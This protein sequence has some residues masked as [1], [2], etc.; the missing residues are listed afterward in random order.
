M[1]SEVYHLSWPAAELGHAL[2]ALAQRS[3]LSP[4]SAELAAP[5][6]RIT[7]DPDAFGRWIE[8]A[9]DSLG[10]EAEPRDVSYPELAQLIRSPGPVL[11]RLPRSV[12][13]AEGLEFRFLAAVAGRRTVSVLGPDLQ[14]HQIDSEVVRAA[15][16]AELEAPVRAQVDQLLDAAQVPTRRRSQARAAILREMLSAQRFSG[17]W[18]IRL[19][20]STPFWQQLRQAGLARHV[21][22]LLAA[23]SFQYFLWLVSWW[24][25]GQGALQGRLDWGWLL[26]WGLLLLTLIPFRLLVTWRQGVLAVGAGGLLKNRLLHGALQL[27]PDDT[28]H[29]GMG[30]LLGRVMEADA[31]ESLALSGG[32]LALIAGIE[33][34]MAAGVLALGAGG[35][36]HALLLVVWLGLITGVG[37]SY[38]RQRQDW[39][40]AR[41]DMTHDLVERMVGHRTR[42]AQQAPQRWHAGEDQALA[43]Y[44]ERSEAMDRS[45][46][47]L[48][49]LAPRGWL[50]VG[51]CGLTPAFVSGAQSAASLAVGIGGLLLAF[52]ALEK[53][54]MSLSHLSGALIAWT[55]IAPLFHAARSS[56]ATASHTPTFLMLPRSDNQSDNRPIGQPVLEAHELNFRYR[57][58]GQAVLDGASVRIG[59]GDRLL[60]E[61]PSGGGKSTLASLLTGLRRPES[62]LL[63]LHGLDWQTIGP[64]A[65][66][67]QIV[68]APQFHENHVLTGTFAF[69]LLM[70]RR[71][72]PKERDVEEAESLCQELGLGELLERMPAGL[73]QMV[74]ETGWQLSHG[75]KSRLYIARALLQGADVIV[76]DESFA[77]LDPQN[78]NRALRC[79]LDRA[80]SLIVIAHP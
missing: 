6:S 70:G 61:G 10:L 34:I 51:L 59:R 21:W 1:H 25:I 58:R 54:V 76:L 77:A 9:A 75:E 37:W 66:R 31:V 43:H 40:D 67:R 46:A 33:L 36:L 29:Q 74:G 79:V 42:L 48:I 44:L 20:P 72:P 11:F 65:W 15:V 55:Q 68:A 7:Q 4:H 17:A 8:T 71:W 13:A 57:D 69:N 53:L 64:Q 60:L 23:H 12:G 52:R 19:P 62:G 24:L 16:C 30:Q 3:G 28:R 22:S 56:G 27:S 32:F 5:D 63:L 2:E 45:A 73:L 26:A 14:M 49:S 41:L 35:W 50:V 78:L 80:P 39:T 47:R 18:S 38:L